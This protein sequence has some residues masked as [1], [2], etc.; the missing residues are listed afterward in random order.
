M[1]ASDSREILEKIENGKIKVPGQPKPKPKKAP[2][3]E[4]S[5][6]IQQE[7]AAHEAENVH[8]GINQPDQ[9]TKPATEASQEPKAE[10]PKVEPKPKVATFPVGGKINKYG[11]IGVSAPICNALGLQPALKGQ[12]G[13]L[14]KNVQIEFSAYDPETRTLTVKIL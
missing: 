11:F 2:K 1:A 5:S 14:T 7:G 3:S 12:K 9:A 13:K 4:S 6:V 8:A 10:K